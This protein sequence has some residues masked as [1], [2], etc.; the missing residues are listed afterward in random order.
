MRHGK[1]SR[2][3]CVKFQDD[4]ALAH[5][6]KAEWVL[7]PTGPVDSRAAGARSL[8]AEAD[9][10]RIE[11]RREEV[12]VASRRLGLRSGIAQ[13]F[14]V[15]LTARAVP[16]A[17]PSGAIVS[18]NPGTSTPVLMGRRSRPRNYPPAA[19]SKAREPGTIFARRLDLDG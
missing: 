12:G 1:P 18:A 6:T 17:L 5:S 19:T 7:S 3:G 2:R 4:A 13:T 9:Q 10:D 14:T 15:R 11:G 16:P 8:W